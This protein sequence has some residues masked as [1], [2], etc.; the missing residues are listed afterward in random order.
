[1]TDTLTARMIEVAKE[2]SKLFT[3]DKRDG[4]DEFVKTVDEVGEHHPLRD[5][6]FTAHGGMLPDDMKYAM[7]ESAVDAIADAEEDDDI[8]EIADLFAD[9]EPS[10]YNA[11]RLQWVASHL[12]RA[13]YVDDAMQEYGDSLGGVGTGLFDLLGWGWAREAREVFNAM[14]EAIEEE[15]G[16]REEAEGEESEDDEDEK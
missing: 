11:A 10:V 2:W 7:C 4:G 3:R 12:D 1:M 9:E 6:I 16:R 15:A 14:R 5:A 8:S 13:G